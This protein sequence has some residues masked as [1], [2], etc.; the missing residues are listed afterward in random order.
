MRVLATALGRHV[1]NRAFKNLQQRLLHAFAAHIAGDRRVFV[2]LGNFVDLID[3][4]D[5]L[6][7]LLNI[8]IGGLQQ[9]Q[10]NVL[11]VFADVTG[12]G[13]R[14]GVHDGER[15]IQHARKRLRQERFAGA[16]RA[17]QKNVGLAQLDVAR[18][19]VQE[20]ALVMIVDGDGELL[21]RAILPNDVAIQKLFDLRRTRQACAPARRL[22]HAFHLPEWS[23]KRRRIRCRCTRADSPKES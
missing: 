22:A 8:A 6:L 21:L 14:R 10:N 4:D 3:I 2:L 13:Q 9:L 17:N 23:G 19:L 16:G 7:S 15:N 1:G 5:A 18:L 12:F 11:D 20:N